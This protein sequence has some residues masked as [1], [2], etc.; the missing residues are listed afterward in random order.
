[1]D[2]ARL[3]DNQQGVGWNLFNR[4]F[5]ALAAGDVELA[6][7]TAEQSIDILKDLDATVLSGWAYMARAAALF[8]AGDAEL[9][10]DLLVAEVGGEE[11][12]LIPG[13][14]ARG[15]ARAADALPA[16]RRPA[17][18]GRARR[19]GGGGVCRGGRVADG[20]GDVRAW[21]TRRSTSTPAIRRAPPSG[22]SAAAALLDGAGAAFFAA[23]S[24]MLAGRALAQAG[25]P[26][27]ATVELERAAA[28]FDSFGVCPVPGSGRARAARAR[29]PDPPAHAGRARPTRRASRR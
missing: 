20:R 2:A 6:L 25:E 19:R 7:A 15:R 3:V 12:Q 23:T 13:R 26:D 22:R 17:P 10:A 29:S 27:R 11:L 5:A 1:M 8:E 16:R 9:A 21:P 14:L 24:R 28:A 4:S 18:G